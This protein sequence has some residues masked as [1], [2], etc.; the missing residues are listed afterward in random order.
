MKGTIMSK[1]SD[2]NV[3]L[4]T[5]EVDLRESTAAGFKGEQMTG[6]LL[7]VVIDTTDGRRVKGMVHQASR[8]VYPHVKK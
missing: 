7:E 4:K 1:W 8:S 5:E 6:G 3:E 2:V